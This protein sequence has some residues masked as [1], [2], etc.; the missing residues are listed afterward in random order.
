MCIVNI[1]HTHYGSRFKLSNSFTDHISLLR[2]RQFSFSIIETLK[3]KKT[4]TITRNYPKVRPWCQAS[5]SRLK[6]ES[7]REWSSFLREF[8]IVQSIIR[9]IPSL[10]DAR[11]DN[12]TL[13]HDTTRSYNILPPP[14]FSLSLSLY[15]SL[16][17]SLSMSIYL[18][19]YIYIYFTLS[20]S[21]PISPLSIAHTVFIS[22]YL[23]LS[24]S[25]SL[26]SLSIYLSLSLSISLPISSLS[27]ALSIT[28]SIYLSLSIS[29]YLSP[30]LSRFLSFSLSLSL[31]LS[32][33][34]HLLSMTK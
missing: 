5:D 14:P 17:L 15:A 16:S 27:F 8:D 30:S 25:L 31:P 29:L 2:V 28:L 4:V 6:I 1:K 32:S 34:Y 24:L 3:F 7:I 21:L 23:S 11:V 33:L 20:F 22:P 19:L 9:V 13:L 10:H 18:S 12:Y 26:L